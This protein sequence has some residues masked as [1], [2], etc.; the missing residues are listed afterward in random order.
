MALRRG[1]WT[2]LLLLS[3][4]WGGAFFFV[5]VAV[6]DLPPLTVVVLR[7]GI[8]AAVL[9]VVLRAGGRTPRLAMDTLGPYAAMGLLNNVVPFSLL[10]WAQTAI[11][12]G[13]AA[14]L[15]ATTPLFAM[16]LAH[17]LLKDEPMA[18]N[19]VGGVLLGIV[20]V[21]MLLGFSLRSG[22]DVGD[23]AM[24]ACLLAAASYGMASVYG[25]RFRAMRLQPIQVACGQLLAST[26]I[27]LPVV[28]MVDAPWRLAPPGMPAVAAVIALATVS[29][30]LAY[31]VF[32]RLLASVGAVDTALV[33]L[34]IP[35]S[36]VALGWLFLDEL[37]EP[38]QLA[39]M[40]IIALGL[41]M[42]D[43]RLGAR[44][45]ARRR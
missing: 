43:G 23:L 44:L 24:V 38:H 31:V 26:V 41:L 21:A 1:D 4:L 33:T 29:T 36:A 16:L 11:T 32:F 17:V 28:G 45:P 42:V 8:A 10:F 20:G 5:A 2:L 15:N 13:L 19:R 9:A 39:G 3:M 30:A 35:P 22:A 27:M 7:T 25:R 18:W 12:S 14:I 34:L 37:L 6:R 40:G